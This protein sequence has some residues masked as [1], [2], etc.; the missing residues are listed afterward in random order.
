[1]D[2]ANQVAMLFSVA[3]GLLRQENAENASQ[4]DPQV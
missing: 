4:L 3:G 1:M 2:E